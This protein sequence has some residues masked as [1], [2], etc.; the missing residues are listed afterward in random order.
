MENVQ[1]KCDVTEII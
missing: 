1:Y